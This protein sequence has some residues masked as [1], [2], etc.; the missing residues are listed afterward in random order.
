M[1]PPKAEGQR[2][3]RTDLPIVLHEQANDRLTFG[4]VR[5]PWRAILGIEADIGL[6]LR[7]V[8]GEVEDVL[9]GVV[10]T[11]VAERGIEVALP[12]LERSAELEA[13]ATGVPGEHVTPLVVVL[14]EDRRAAVAESGDAAGDGD[15]GIWHSAH[16]PS[17]RTRRKD[18][19]ASFR[20]FGENV[21]VQFRLTNI[22]YC[23]PSGRKAGR[24]VPPPVRMSFL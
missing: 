15:V 20:T 11:L 9:E 23:S 1:F 6:P 12:F 8:I 17:P 13:M 7:I 3:V 4:Y 14:N 5:N 19:A 24:T 21:R 16:G 10:R 22:V 18:P 2:E